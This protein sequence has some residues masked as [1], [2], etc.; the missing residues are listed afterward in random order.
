MSWHN[1]AWTL[2]LH[3][4]W[5]NLGFSNQFQLDKIK[6][7]STFIFSMNFLSLF[8]PPLI[9]HVWSMIKRLKRNSPDERRDHMTDTIPAMSTFNSWYLTPRQESKI[10]IKTS[11]SHSHPTEN[12]HT[13]PHPKTP[14]VWH[15]HYHEIINTGFTH[16]IGQSVWS[17]VHIT[18]AFKFL[19]R[20]WNDTF[21][22]TNTTLY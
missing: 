1:W 20:G 14:S 11:C 21:Q 13:C 22:T 7:Y 17:Q 18:K 5:L 3:L 8:D 19:Y 9:S 10:S 4:T 16:V 6:C 15:Q 2:P 12:V